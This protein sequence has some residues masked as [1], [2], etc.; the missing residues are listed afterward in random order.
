M[1]AGGGRRVA[2]RAAAS[3]R[4]WRS[5]FR[6]RSSWR[7]RSRSVP[8]AGWSSRAR[9]AHSDGKV[10]AKP[11]E[12]SRE[13]VVVTTPPGASVEVDGKKTGEQT[14]A[15]VTRLGAGPHQVRLVA[16]GFLQFPYVIQQRLGAADRES[17]NDNRAPALRGTL[18]DR[19][20]GFGGIRVIMRPVAVGRLDH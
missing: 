6:R 18:D 4:S 13:L 1:N 15:V 12:T 14:P 16:P 10:V 9:W 19:S 11:I 7:R 17:R 2:C 20:Q 5:G 8:W 3:R